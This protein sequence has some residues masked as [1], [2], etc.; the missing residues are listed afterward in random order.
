MSYQQQHQGA[1]D[2]SRRQQ[3]APPFPLLGTNGAAA[4]GR[5]PAAGV[6]GMPQQYGQQQQQQADG[7]GGPPPSP[8]VAGSWGERTG[9]V[10]EGYMRQDPNIVAGAGTPIASTTSGNGEGTFMVSTGGANAMGAPLQS[11]YPP[12]L[13]GVPTSV[14]PYQQ[15]GAFPGPYGGGAGGGA[16]GTAGG[17]GSTAGGNF[18]AGQGGYARSTNP[19]QPIQTTTN[20]QGPDGCNLFV[21][22]IPNTMTN[23]ALFRLFS[24]FGNVISARIM[25]EKAT[26]R[27]RG[28]GFVS[29]DNRDSAEKA[30]SQMNG[31]QIEHKRLKVQHKK[32]KERERYVTAPSPRMMGPGVAAGRMQQ[33]TH[34]RQPLLP[35]HNAGLRHH[36]GGDDKLP[37]PSPAADT[38]GA[39]VA[40]GFT[41][42]GGGGGGGGGGGEEDHH[43]GDASAT[44]VGID[45]GPR[46]ASTGGGDKYGA[47]SNDHPHLAYIYR[48]RG[49]ADET[50][51]YPSAG[52]GVD[53][54]AA[55]DEKPQ[56]QDSGYHG[57]D[58]TAYMAAPASSVGGSGAS[59]DPKGV[60]RARSSSPSAAA[61]AA[62]PHQSLEHAMQTKLT[63]GGNGSPPSAAQP[64]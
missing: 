56:D 4:A 12:S 34:F 19:G 55:G 31:Y 18:Y 26:G 24:K 36:Q 44:E 54:K 33:T 14:Y 1:P 59:P 35:G 40:P 45:S 37:P 41:V 51:G 30:I 53:G 23:E 39:G 3:Q 28:F 46:G 11:F 21:F 2:G 43:Q 13:Y 7:Y 9:Y 49:T 17:A 62:L 57:R 58:D 6:Y 10:E 8:V 63:M 61:N 64:S 25:V 27:S 60:S 29:Y 16:G 22:H 15:P 20:L 48:G 38:G 5:A 47:R 50:G 42:S 52:G 32:D